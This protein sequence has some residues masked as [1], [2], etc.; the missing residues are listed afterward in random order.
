MALYREER[1]FV[2]KPWLTIG[3]IS[4]LSLTTIV[5]THKYKHKHTYTDT[6]T[7]RSIC[8]F[9]SLERERTK[10]PRATFTFLLKNIH[11]SATHRYNAEITDLRGLKGGH[12]ALSLSLFLSPS[13]SLLTLSFSLS[14]SHRVREHSII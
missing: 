8:Y 2:N 6:H 5:V 13:L 12:K 3:V 1:Y 7:H 9:I 4:L 11:K 14:L 10:R